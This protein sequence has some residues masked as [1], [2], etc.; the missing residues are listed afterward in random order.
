MAQT[1]QNSENN[2]KQLHLPY[3]HC[4]NCG[5]ELKGCYCHNCGQEVVDKTPTVWGFIIEYL[6]NAFIW[7]TKF[8]KTLWTLISRPGHLTNE[9]IAG[10][11]VSQEHPLKLNMFLLFVFVTLFVFFAG[12]EKMT[13]SVH[14]V[15][16]DERV[17][18]GVKLEFLMKDQEYVKHIQESPRDTILLHAP[19]FLAEQYPQILSNI[20]TKEDTEG[21]SL[22][23]WVAVVPQ[24]LIA[25]KIIVPDKGGH[26]RFNSEA[27]IGKVELGYANS[28][29]AEMVS[30]LSKY[31]PMLLLLTAPFLSA[32]LNLVQRR[33]RLPRINHFI[34]ALHYTA[35]LEFLMI[36]IYI[37][38]LTI[39]PSMEVMQWIIIVGSCLYL[40]IAFRKVY[41]TRNWSIAIIKSLLT[42]LTY[43]VILLFITV[44]IF[45]TS[46][47]MVAYQSI[48]L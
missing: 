34:F 25:D 2:D 9:Y 41:A 22:D 43:F 16:N 15:T 18:S 26:Y 36:C 19:L 3:T 10:K 13:N 28:I 27:N 44:A 48:T 11:F 1:I 24:V 21:K 17:L 47:F 5:E 30:I 23:K 46:C 8:V 20:E 7:D 40:T 29:W 6:N 32:S 33:S 45:L 4:L 37:L 31:F 42:S 14:S 38:H 35:L 12:T 39:A